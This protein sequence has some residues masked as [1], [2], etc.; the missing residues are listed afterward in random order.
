MASATLSQTP[1]LSIKAALGEV[2]VGT[3]ALGAPVLLG[4]V[5]VGTAALRAAVLL[6]AVAVGTAVLGA[7]ALDRAALG[8]GALSLRAL[9]SSRG[10]ANRTRTAPRAAVA[11]NRA[12][13]QAPLSLK[14]ETGDVASEMLSPTPMPSTKSKPPPK[15]MLSTT[16]ALGTVAL[17]MAA[18]GTVALGAAALGTVVLGTAALGTVALGMSALEMARPRDPSSSRALVRAT[19]T[20]LAAAADSSRA[21]APARWWR[22]N[23]MVDVV[24]GMRSLTTMRPKRCRDGLIGSGEE[25]EGG[26]L[27]ER[28]LCLCISVER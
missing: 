20:V 18:L 7:A 24:L 28:D 6:G 22:R 21:S 11:S 2:V 12:N 13:A 14:S 10:C 1:M 23:A 5:V 3:A 17:G 19:R 26:P 27:G 9:S 8:P 25:V 4:A 15:P 16:V